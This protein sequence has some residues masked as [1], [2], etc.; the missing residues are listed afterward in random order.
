MFFFSRRRVLEFESNLKLKNLR[1]SG[2]VRGRFNRF[3]EDES[4]S[5]GF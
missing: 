4:N 1:F 2:L 5:C 3:G